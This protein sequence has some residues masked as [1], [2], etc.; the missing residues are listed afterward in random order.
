MTFP[1]LPMTCSLRGT[2]YENADRYNEGRNLNTHNFSPKE[3]TI[4]LPY[5]SSAGWKATTQG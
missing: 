5:L 4:V 2:N 1:L 3:S